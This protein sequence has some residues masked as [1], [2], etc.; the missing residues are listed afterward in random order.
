M[1]RPMK[2][3]EDGSMVAAFYSIYNELE[4][5]GHKPKLDALNNEF[6]LV[7]QNICYP[8]KPPARMLKHTIIKLTP[9]SRPWRRQNIT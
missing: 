6:S 9:Q 4:T 1:M 5:K 2:S 8:K 7:V 3:R